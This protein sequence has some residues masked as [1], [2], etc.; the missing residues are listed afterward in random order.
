VTLHIFS[1]IFGNL[2][3]LFG[4]MSTHD[5]NLLFNQVIGFCYRVVGANYA[6]WKLTPYLILPRAGERGK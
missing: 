1:Y 6:V 5:F 2:Y 4:K 3:F